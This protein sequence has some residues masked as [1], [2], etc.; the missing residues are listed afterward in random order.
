VFIGTP[1]R[2]DLEDRVM[3]LSILRAASVPPARKPLAKPDLQKQLKRFVYRY[4][5]TVRHIARQHKALA[6]L[7][8]SF[9]ALLF[10]LAC[11]HK[12]LDRAAVIQAVIW[13]VP[14]KQLAKLAQIPFWMAKLPPEAFDQPLQAVPDDL[15]F[16]ARVGNALPEKPKLACRWLRG[17]YVLH[18]WGSGEFA[19]WALPHALGNKAQ[20][21]ELGC[22]RAIALH[23]W[24]SRHGSGLGV[25]CMQQRWQPSLSFEKARQRAVAWIDMLKAHVQQTAQPI[26]DF[27]FEPAVVDGFAIEPLRDSHAIIAEGR[28]MKNCIASYVPE[29][30]GDQSRL[31]RVAQNNKTIAIAEISAGNGLQLLAVTQLRGPANKDVPPEVARAVRR[32]QNM[33]AEH[34]L[35]PRKAKDG[36][37]F[38]QNVWRDIWRP[39]WKHKGRP[40]LWLPFVGDEDKLSDLP[41]G[42]NNW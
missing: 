4:R 41:Y 38:Q 37:V 27:W 5:N 8:F 36:P 25:K 35:T 10:A 32:W 9:P 29:V 23:A 15:V 7:A 42:G 19:L 39:Y 2:A 17:L 34:Q 12:K 3:T 24:Y 30:Y 16:N 21:W 6:D 11:P 1:C 14:L 20:H 40:T 18:D 13:G 31:W 28:Q 26:E 22:M 33:Q